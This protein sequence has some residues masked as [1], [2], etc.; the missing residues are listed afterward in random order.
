MSRAAALVSIWPCGGICLRVPPSVPTLPMLLLL[1][2][3]EW[4]V[5]GDIPRADVYLP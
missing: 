4:M 1:L 5:G 2:L 3:I